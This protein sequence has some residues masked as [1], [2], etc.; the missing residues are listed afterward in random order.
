MITYEC[1]CVNE[2]GPPMRCLTKCAFH[3]QWSL[4][5]PSGRDYYMAQLGVFDDGII[6]CARYEQEMRDA[7]CA[8]H[9]KS[10]YKLNQDGRVIEFG[11]GCSP[12]IPWLR[13]Y[14]YHD[15]LGIEPSAWAARWTRDTYGVEVIKST[16]ED[17]D[18][19]KY[20]D[21]DL[22]LAAHV[23][24]HTKEAPAALAKMTEHLREGGQIIILVPDSQDPTN[25]DHWWFFTEESLVTCME[26]VG[27]KRVRAVTKRIVQ[28]E[29]YIFATGERDD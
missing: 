29:Q 14:G 23:L 13:S 3:K 8:F 26:Q 28:H 20:G 9:D 25:P 1:G 5:H 7:L 2:L 10:F 19:A 16:I 11:C 27:L 6:Q 4:D 15:Y 22:V 17:L 21:R 24:E 12:Y 18:P